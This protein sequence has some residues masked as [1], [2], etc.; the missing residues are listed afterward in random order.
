MV[1]PEGDQVEP[2]TIDALAFLVDAAL[3]AKLW[4]ADPIM[5]QAMAKAALVALKTERYTLGPEHLK[6][7]GEF[8]PAEEQRLRQARQAQLDELMNGNVLL[9]RSAAGCDCGDHPIITLVE[10]ARS[11]SSKTMKVAYEAAVMYCRTFERGVLEVHQAPDEQDEPPRYH[12]HSFV[13]ALWCWRNDQRLGHEYPSDPETRELVQQVEEA[14]LMCC[15]LTS[16]WRR[17]IREAFYKVEDINEDDTHSRLVAHMK[18]QRL[19]GVI[20]HNVHFGGK[21]KEPVIGGRM[22]LS[23]DGCP[24]SGGAS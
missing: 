20:V 11:G 5:A 19:L 9:Q 16:P 2:I 23:C 21:P 18:E 7:I 24:A 22:R 13:E 8:N 3:Y 1:H 10:A 4:Q 17:K 15:T 6:A 12:D 14:L